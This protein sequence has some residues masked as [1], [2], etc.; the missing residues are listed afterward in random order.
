MKPVE[1]F[2][3]IG[4]FPQRYV[5]FLALLKCLSLMFVTAM[6]Y[7]QET[8]GFSPHPVTLIVKFGITADGAVTHEWKEAI[9]DRHNEEALAKI[10]AST[11]RLSEEEALWI[12]LIKRKISTWPAM[13]DSLRIPFQAITPPDTISI[14]LGNLGGEDAFV[15]SY[16]TICFDLNKLGSQYGPATAS[17]N[18]ARID[19]FFAHEFTHVLHKAWRKKK[20]VEFESPFAFALWECLTEDLG[21][22]AHSLTNGCCKA[23]N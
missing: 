12:D 14:L 13:I 2:F 4:L 3:T 20:G 23:A 9:R 16:S 21:I 11:R 6:G 7:C 18:S 15:Y 10:L 22:I 8:T 1:P 19:R 17:A 5:E